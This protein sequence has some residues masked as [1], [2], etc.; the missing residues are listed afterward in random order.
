VNR[1]VNGLA[2]VVVRIVV[3]REVLA[4]ALFRA[5]CR[6]HPPLLGEII[7]SARRVAG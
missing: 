6:V 3:W 1:I 4:Y 5:A 2:W 7:A